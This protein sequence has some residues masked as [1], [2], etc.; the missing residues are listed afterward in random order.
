MGHNAILEIASCLTLGLGLSVAEGTRPAV[1]YIAWLI[2]VFPCVAFIFI[3]MAGKRVRRGSFSL[4]VALVGIAAAFGVSQLVFWRAVPWFLEGEYRLV[5][6]LIPWLPIG[7]ETLRLGLYLDPLSGIMLFMVPLVCGMIFVYS[8]GYMRDDP[9]LD[10]F[11]AYISLFA[12]AMLAL[13]VFDSFLTL[14]IFW[15][16]MGTCSYLLIG[17]WFEREAAFK[18]ALKAFLVTKVGDLFFMLGL[19]LLYAE[20]GSLA[21]GDVFEPQTLQ[22]LAQKP[23]MNTG[24]STATVVSWL[25]FGGT[26]GKSAQFPLHT[27]LPDAMEGPTPV[28][29]LIHAA[30]MV[31]AGVYLIVRAFPL[32]AVSDALGLVALV[33]TFTAI[34]ASVVALAQMDIKRVLAFSTISQLGYMVAAV[35]IGAWVAAMFHLIT[36][37]FF[38]ALLFLASGSVIHGMEHAAVVGDAHS[39]GLNPNDM[40]RM[41]GL[42]KQMPRTALSFLIGGLSLAG[43]PFFTAGFW[44]KDEILTQA[45]RLNPLIFWTLGIAAGLT[46]FYTARQLCLTFLGK[47]RTETAAQVSESTPWMTWPLLGLA[48]FA[49]VLGW[50]GI[51]EE[52]PV[53][54]GWLPNWFHHLV[55]E[56]AADVGPRMVQDSGDGGLNTLSYTGAV[57]P[58]LLSG[59]FALGGLGLGWWVYGR[60]PLTAGAMDP[61]ES[62]MRRLNL[63]W[64]YDLMRHRFYLDEVY[65]AILIEPSV[66][67]ADALAHFD[68][69]GIDTTILIL[70]EPSIRLADALACFDQRG[71][72]A[73]IRRIARVGQGL[74]KVC[75]MVDDGYIDGLINAVGRGSRGAAW[76]AGWFDLY[77]VDFGVNVLAWLGQVIARFSGLFDQRIVDGVVNIIGEFIWWVGGQVRRIQIGLVQDYLWNALFMILLLVAVIVLL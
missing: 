27:W 77:V 69:H 49:V 14:F 73:A 52:F 68:Q 29:A 71:I 21:Y 67:L 38:K 34:F 55:A 64:F 15:E 28:S 5:L 11:F 47:P 1:F 12:A 7:G 33:G 43:F 30:T 2:P 35:G 22:A 48:L 62:A 45:W 13:I 10:R 42:G 9:H 54:G 61:L 40:R 6:P 46:A 74:S 26:L 65:A 8:V 18:A 57:F 72:D 66:R 25:I 58:L 53:V 56:T 60:N 24:L 16:I 4:A 32:F 17:F 75:G 36:H 31:S 39:L 3:A 37:A 44:S 51:P 63:A 70:V 20:I 23:L 41:G 19:A 76:V 59:A 50:V